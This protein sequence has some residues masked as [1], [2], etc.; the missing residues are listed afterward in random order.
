MRATRLYAFPLD[1][2]IFTTNYSLWPCPAN[3]SDVNGERAVGSVLERL[4]LGADR[5][6][7][8]W[9]APV[10]RAPFLA[11]GFMS[12]SGVSSHSKPPEASPHPRARA[13]S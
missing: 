6:A 11:Q 1:H 8:A 9:D 10:Q 12:G 7:L 3:R 2:W 4:V 5:I 13:R